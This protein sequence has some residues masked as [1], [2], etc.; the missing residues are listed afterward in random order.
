MHA[1]TGN[2]LG[3]EVRELTPLS[4]A[5]S[6]ITLNEREMEVAV[7]YKVGTS[8]S[9]EVPQSTPT[10]TTG[11]TNGSPQITVCFY[12]SSYLA[13]SSDISRY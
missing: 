12:H 3:L 5:L 2:Y 1:T 9:L 8:R 11:A 4:A 7:R 13:H 10:S 6:R